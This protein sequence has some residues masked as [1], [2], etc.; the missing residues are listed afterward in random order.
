LLVVCAAAPCGC[1]IIETGHRGLLF[2]PMRGGTQHEVLAPGY[3]RLGVWDRV[4]DFDVTFSTRKEEVQAQSSEGLALDVKLAVIYRPIASELYELDTEIGPNY[5][6]EVVGP[7]FRSAARGVLARHSYL[8]LQKV[9]E[10]VEDDIE[11]ELRRRITGRHVEVTSVT[12]EAIDYA[13]EIAAEIRAKLVGEQE[14]LRRKAQI[15][16]DAEKARLLAE[17]ALRER[18]RERALAEEQATI[19]RLRAKA[20]AES[21]LVRAK[22]QAE[23][24][25]LLARAHAEEMRAQSATLT[26]LAVQ[27]HAYDALA[28]LGGAGTTVLLGDWSHVPSFLFP[29]GGMMPGFGL[30]LDRPRAER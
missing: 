11:G 6:D 23:E 8:E 17:E 5:Y 10:R 12:L 2:E 4:D 20:E 29:R 22:A 7:E 19:D 30:A 3:H 25:T 24:T 28:K 21:R 1:A 15:E 18:Q 13:P 16:S 27:M 26:P 14:T 9:N